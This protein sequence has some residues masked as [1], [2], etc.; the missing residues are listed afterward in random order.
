MQGE[1]DFRFE[2]E[3]FDESSLLK[4]AHFRMIIFLVLLGDGSSDLKYRDFM[5]CWVVKLLDSPEV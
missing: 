5:N 2:S 3:F 1:G 4:A